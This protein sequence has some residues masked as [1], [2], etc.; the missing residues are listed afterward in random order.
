MCKSQA[1][2]L[3]ERDSITMNTFQ[4]VYD[5]LMTQEWE[6][7]HRFYNLDELGWTWGYNN[8]KKALGMCKRT[9]K[10]GHL[11]KQILISKVLLDKNIKGN[12]KEFEDTIRHE[13][14]HAIDYEM[15]DTSDHGY[16]WQRV[17]IQVGANPTSCKKVVGADHKWIGT[18]P[19][20][21][22]TN[23]RH[24]LRGNAKY[25]ACM[26]CCKEYNGGGYTDEYQL[27]WVKQF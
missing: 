11:F 13:I 3:L 12:A 10:H 5:I 14:A 17:A 20:C 9:H 27:K 6:V 16:R 2:L 18:C 15:R 25:G 4:R 1:N 8:A 22:R 23:K 19:K 7:D 26:K 21:K 24:S